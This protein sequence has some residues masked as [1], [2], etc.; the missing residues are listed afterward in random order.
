MGLA[1]ENCRACAA[2]VRNGSRKT[3]GKRGFRSMQEIREG[4]GMRL[5]KSC[6]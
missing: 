3:M 6:Q 4:G 1:G 5:V 2:A